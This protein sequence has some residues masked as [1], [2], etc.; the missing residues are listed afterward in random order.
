[1]IMYMKA[2]QVVKTN[3][4]V[5][6]V[7]NVKAKEDGKDEAYCN[8]GQD[9]DATHPAATPFHIDLGF[10]NVGFGPLDISI[11]ISHLLS[12]QIYLLTLFKSQNPN[13]FQQFDTLIDLFFKKED[14]LSFGFNVLKCVGQQ[15]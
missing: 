2:K 11:C 15:G 6:K 10:F 3:S 12:Y 7:N 9:Y 8:Q 1:M 14:F 5:S 4:R 13:Y